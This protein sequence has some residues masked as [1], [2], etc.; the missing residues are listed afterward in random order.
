MGFSIVGT[1]KTYDRF[2]VQTVG[3]QQ[4][5]PSGGWVRQSWKALRMTSRQDFSG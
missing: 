1:G 5:M 2:P 3:V 4:E